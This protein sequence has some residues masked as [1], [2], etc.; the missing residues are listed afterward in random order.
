MYINFILLSIVKFK[1]RNKKQRLKPIQ[2]MQNSNSL[3]PSN[4][5]ESKEEK[6][7]TSNATEIIV[8]A[9]K[10]LINL[11][12]AMLKSLESYRIQIQRLVNTNFSIILLYFML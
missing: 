5:E 9:A 11:M 1:F 6:A 2:K 4:L 3:E 8:D 7:G 10:K 12:K